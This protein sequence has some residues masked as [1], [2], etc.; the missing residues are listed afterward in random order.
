MSTEYLRERLQYAPETGAFTWQAK[1]EVTR[2]DRMFNTRFAGQTAGSLTAKGYVTIGIDGA[3]YM[4][5]KLALFYVT[6]EWPHGD[7]DHENRNK[8]DNRVANLR[9]ATRSQNKGN[10]GPYAT[11]K[12]GERGVSWYQKTQK[13]VAQICV[14]GRKKTLGYYE[15]IDAAKAAYRT[16]AV[17]AFGE[18]AP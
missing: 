10:A 5:H 16:A 4:A 2:H 12:S 3:Y 14:D 6:G 11:S 13:W 8:Q 17:S 15:D 1:R 18:F 9:V 7:V